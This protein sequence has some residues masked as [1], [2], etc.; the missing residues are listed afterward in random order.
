MRNASLWSLI[1]SSLRLLGTSRWWWLLFII[2]RSAKS[3]GSEGIRTFWSS[4]RKPISWKMD[5]ILGISRKRIITTRSIRSC[6][7]LFSSQLKEDTWISW[8]S[9][10]KQSKSIS[11]YASEILSTPMSNQKLFQFGN[12]V[13]RN[14]SPSSFASNK[15]TKRCSII[16]WTICINYGLSR[17]FKSYSNRFQR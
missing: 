1:W 13:K 14:V 3:W 10:S 8:D 16:W 15:A 12:T 9:W 11:N 2:W 5:Q 7:I 17:S 4:L 6:G